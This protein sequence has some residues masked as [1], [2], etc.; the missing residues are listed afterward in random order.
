MIKY[1]SCIVFNAV[2]IIMS[3]ISLPFALVDVFTMQRLS[4]NSLSIVWLEQPLATEL[5]QK[6]TQEFRQFETIFIIP[7]S[8]PHQFQVRIFTMEEELPFAGH[9][10]LGAASWLHNEYFAN[11]LEVSL[12]LITPTKSIIVES[13]RYP[14][15]YQ[16]TMQQGKGMIQT[17]LTL[18][19]AQSFLTAL[20][21]TENDFHPILPLQVI[22]TG[23]E[24]LIV[25]V[26]SGLERTR[27][28]H[29]DFEKLLSTVGA[30]FVYVFDTSTRE[31][32]TWD[33]AGLVE[34]SAT[35]SAAGP[36]ALYLVK[37]GLAAIDE[38]ILIK[39]GGFVGRPSE[40]YAQVQADNSV[41]V[42]GGVVLM[43]M[44]QLWV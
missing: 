39:Q 33:N 30:K 34:D 9:P 10:I 22:S 38:T 35:G 31:G 18:Q 29:N 25:P 28:V 12:N 19:Q 1:Y 37:H 27:I 8:R 21:L 4:G 11:E 23:L 5:M 17:P 14:H 7:T 6:I 13:E 40:L 3:K 24:Y 44:G 42:S 16:A 41:R 32:R 26:Q 43:G 2:S 15:Y 20:N 36:V